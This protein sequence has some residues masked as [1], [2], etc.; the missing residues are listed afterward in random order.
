MEGS[1]PKPWMMEKPYLIEQE[2]CTGCQICV[3]ECP[4]N[5]ITLE[6]DVTKP[7]SARPKPVI[8][9]RERIKEDG[10]WH[11]LSEY[12]CDFLKRPVRSPLSA[13]SDWKPMT[14]ERGLSQ[15]WRTMKKPAKEPKARLKPEAEL[16]RSSERTG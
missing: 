7:L 12:T 5:A 11:P 16:P 3:R 14:R 13:L 1:D 9:K 6:L 10:L 15:T 8:L 4:T 2:R